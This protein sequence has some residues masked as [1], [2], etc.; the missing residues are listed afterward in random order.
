MSPPDIHADMDLTIFSRLS[1]AREI[2]GVS[3]QEEILILSRRIKVFFF[4]E[5]NFI[6][7]CIDA[8]DSMLD[9]CKFHE[10]LFVKRVGTLVA[11]L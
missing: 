10:A 11:I 9:R 2:E 6:R 4:F 7:R 1:F 5:I 8:Y 3:G